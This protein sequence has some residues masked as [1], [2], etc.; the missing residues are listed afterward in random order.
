MYAVVRTGGKQARVEEGQRLE[1]ERL[2]A[3]VGDDVSFTP[4]LVVDGATVL[5][6]PDELAGATVSA[7]VVGESKGPKV[8]G[9]K[10][11]PK[12]RSRVR[13]GHRQGYDTIEITSIALKGST[14]E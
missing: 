7:T 8:T 13:W 5:A 1:V 4:I 3:A 11:K 10:Y 6:S 14:D 9:F 12:S 2:G